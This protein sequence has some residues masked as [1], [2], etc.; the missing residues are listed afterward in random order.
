[1]LCRDRDSEGILVT[2]M[3]TL[4]AGVCQ[5]QENVCSAA[6]AITKVPIPS[7]FRQAKEHRAGT[8]MSQRVLAGWVIIPLSG[9]VYLS[10][11]SGPTPCLLPAP[12]AHNYL[13]LLSYHD[14]EADYVQKPWSEQE[15]ACPEC[16]NKAHDSTALGKQPC[17]SREM[18]TI[19]FS[20]RWGCYCLA[21]WGSAPVLHYS[22][23]GQAVGAPPLVIHLSPGSRSVQW[24]ITLCSDP[25]EFSAA[26]SS[27]GCRRGVGGLTG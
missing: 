9:T 6:L 21:G 5:S 16:P 25:F 20:T 3:Q 24:T 2:E 18:S 22:C 4:Y 17:V 8:G 27:C 23:R 7:T 10:A 14:A 19:S 26:A 13:H 15:A 11:L 1:M 12:S